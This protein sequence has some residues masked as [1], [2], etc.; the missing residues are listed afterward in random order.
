[1]S[2]EIQ[3]IEIAESAQKCYDVICDFKRYS[4]WQK[5]VE[6]IMI[7]DSEN[8]RP[9][10][11]EFQV[12]AVMKTVNYTLQYNYDESNP[13]KMK[14][15]WTYVGGD[16]KNIEGNYVFEEI[17]DKKTIATYTLNLELGFSVPKFLLD[18]MKVASM[19]EVLSALKKRT[20]AKN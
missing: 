7:L 6:K 16:V 11:V 8:G 14:L 15:A 20:E 17:S 18:K 3:K 13:K 12:N 1:M 2:Q 10:V 19:Q 5:N 9:S 4:E